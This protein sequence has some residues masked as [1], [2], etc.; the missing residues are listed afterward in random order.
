M[1]NV[2]IMH[3]YVQE[4]NDAP[5]ELWSQALDFALARADTVEFVVDRAQ[6]R[7]PSTLKPFS[8]ILSETFSSRW[9]WQARQLGSTTFARFPLTTEVASYLRSLPNVGYWLGD[10]PEDPALYHQDVAVLWTISHER[11][12]FLWL[13]QEE[14]TTL[15]AAGFTLSPTGNDLSPTRRPLTR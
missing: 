11:L 9:R 10:Y 2:M 8:A 5:V 3:Y 1:R 12:A 6:K 4:M 15:N 14:A 13:T 7:W